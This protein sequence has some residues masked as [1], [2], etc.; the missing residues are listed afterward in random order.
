M[1]KYISKKRFVAIGDIETIFYRT[2]IKD[3][4]IAYLRAKLLRVILE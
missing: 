4:A 2:S 3:K 1:L